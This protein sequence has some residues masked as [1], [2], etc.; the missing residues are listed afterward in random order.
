[1]SN[2]LTEMY[3]NLSPL[4]KCFHPETSVSSKLCTCSAYSYRRASTGF[5]LAACQL[6]QLTVSIEMPKASNPANENIQR[7]RLVL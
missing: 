6:C 4:F 2:F 3:N 5:L 7:L 1:M